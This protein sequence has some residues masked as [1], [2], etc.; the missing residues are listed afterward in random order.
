MRAVTIAMVLLSAGVVQAQVKTW[1]VEHIKYELHSA[2][3]ESGVSIVEMTV[4][5]MDGFNEEEGIFE[6]GID[7][8]VCEPDLVWYPTKS[9]F[10]LIRVNNKK[11]ILLKTLKPGV[12]QRIRLVYDTV[13]AEKIRLY[14]KGFREQ[15]THRDIKP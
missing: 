7:A 9:T 4:T 10:R 13:K 11:S 14:S 12:P 6:G 8:E 3:T 1:R 5:N 2:K 15:T